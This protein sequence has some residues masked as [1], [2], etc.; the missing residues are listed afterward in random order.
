MADCRGERIGCTDQ[1]QYQEQYLEELPF[2]RKSI[3]A[4]WVFKI[5][6]NNNG[7]P[8]KYKARLVAKGYLQRKGIDYR[9]TFAPVVRYESIR[10]LLA[11]AASKDYEL[12]QFDIT[13]AFLYGDLDEEIFME[14]PEGCNTAQGDC[15]QLLKSLYG[16]K[17][18]PRQ[19]NKKFNEF[20][21]QHNF[22]SNPADPCIF[23]GE[24]NGEEVLLALY[25]DDG[26]LAAK[27]KQTIDI[28]LKNL[29]KNFEITIGKADHYVGLQISRKR[30]TKEIFV[31]QR[32]YLKK[33]VEKFGMKDCKGSSV[34]A[35]GRSRL[36]SEM[37]PTSKEEQE[38]M[39]A[40]PYRQAIGSLMFAAVVSRPDIAFS[41]A[42]VSRFL[43]KQGTLDRCKEDSTICRG[44]FGLWVAV[45]SRR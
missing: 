43:E 45:Q 31:N 41:V 21:Y 14:L 16:L 34:P 9:E 44:N 28:V 35:E 20:L 2:G 12:G 15:C 1:E 5:K 26:L 37:S 39:L 13:T 42:N 17:Q 25:V 38:D 33:V 3:K 8:I 24:V 18:S 36:S 32:A 10:A 19:W 22:K 27:S 29:K 23:R 7:D 30:E 40:I 6:R 11:V 4:K